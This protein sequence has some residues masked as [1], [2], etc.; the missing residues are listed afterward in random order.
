MYHFVVAKY[1]S[2]ILI[3][4]QFVSNDIVRSM[5]TRQ[6]HLRTIFSYHPQGPKGDML[7]N[8]SSLPRLPVPPL[9]QSLKKYL[10]AIQPIVNDMEYQKTKEIVKLFG[11]K[12]GEGEKLQKALEERA[13]T[14]DSWVSDCCY[15]RV[16]SL[17][18]L[19]GTFKKDFMPAICF[20]FLSLH[21]F[22]N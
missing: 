5:A 21:C 3:L 18:I 17:F 19:Y 16:L 13:K 7:K 6:T 4:L 22:N 2:L 9:Q 14:H 1:I 8:Q 15:D 12:D 11:K 10:K 20:S